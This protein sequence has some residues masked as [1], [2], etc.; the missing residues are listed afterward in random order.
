MTEIKPE[1]GRTT[2]NTELAQQALADV[3]EAIKLRQAREPMAPPV[4]AWIQGTW[5]CSSGMCYAGFVVEAAGRVWANGTYKGATMDL[6]LADQGEPGSWEYTLFN[7]D[8]NE[9]EKVQA[10]TARAAA[11]NLLGDARVALPHGVEILQNPSTPYQDDQNTVSGWLKTAALFDGDNELEPI[12]EMLTY[13]A[14]SAIPRDL[15][16]V[17]AGL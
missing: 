7:Y 11:L 1:T 2:F 5:R 15:G 14:K 8:T 13:L 12:E 6:L 3:K 4:K 10:I 16:E 9:W 17:D